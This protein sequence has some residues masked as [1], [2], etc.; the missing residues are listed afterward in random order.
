MTVKLNIF[1]LGK[2]PVDLN[3]SSLKVNWIEVEEVPLNLID[4]LR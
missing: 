4:L 3:D 2:Q 1:D